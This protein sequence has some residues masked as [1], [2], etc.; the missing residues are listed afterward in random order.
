MWSSGHNL[1]IT[2]GPPAPDQRG[3]DVAQGPPSPPPGQDECALEYVGQP[4][5]VT[6]GNMY[7]QQ[8]DVAYPSAFGR[9]PLIR[10]YNSQSTYAGSLGLGWTHTYDYEVQE[11][12]P[13]VIR[14]RNGAGNIRY[15]EPIAGGSTYR[16]VAPARDLSRLVKHAEGYT[17]TEQDGL[18]RDFDQAGRL[19][20]IA[21]RAGWATTLTYADGRL[22][23]VTG[24]GGRTLT[25]SYLGD[26][27]LARV[28][29][30][31]GLFA[32]YR[33]DAPVSW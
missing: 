22:A 20:A 12:Q 23:T 16:V 5:N 4:I 19:L 11:V 31:G 7:T 3:T 21:S 10:T 1:E 26:G 14:V 28:D 27:H 9:F 8:E 17:E 30:P 25:F 2:F 15:Y 18:R 6:T 33:Y 24:P 13:G 29:G 32:E